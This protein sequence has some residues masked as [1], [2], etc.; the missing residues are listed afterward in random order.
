[1]RHNIYPIVANISLCIN[2]QLS[3]CRYRNICITFTDQWPHHPAMSY[4]L[5]THNSLIKKRPVP[6]WVG[7]HRRAMRGRP[8]DRRFCVEHIFVVER[9]CR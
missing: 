3:M 2:E 8:Q 7:G 1:M 9:Y 4:L 5:Y 6:H